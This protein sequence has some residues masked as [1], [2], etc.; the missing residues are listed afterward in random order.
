MIRYILLESNNI[1]ADKLVYSVLPFD[2][3]RT[4]FGSN[5]NIFLNFRVDLPVA[6]LLPLGM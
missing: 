1:P 2:I 5:P 6:P 3:Y 4:G